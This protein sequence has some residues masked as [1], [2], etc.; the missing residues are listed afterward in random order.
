MFNVSL[1]KEN[2]VY[3]GLLYAEIEVRHFS[4]RDYKNILVSDKLFLIYL[5]VVSDIHTTFEEYIFM[6]QAPLLQ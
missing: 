1:H 3:E 2:E 4:N 6:R 5:I